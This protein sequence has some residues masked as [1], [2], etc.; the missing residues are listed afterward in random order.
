MILPV[1]RV[2]EFFMQRN[3]ISFTQS[4]QIPGLGTVQGAKR[5]ELQVP[6]KII[7]GKVCTGAESG[8]SLCMFCCPG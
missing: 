2:S 3:H 6:I 7:K 1:V 8:D 4:L 5:N